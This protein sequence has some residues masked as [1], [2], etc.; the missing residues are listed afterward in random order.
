MKNISALILTCDKNSDI[1]QFV[2]KTVDLLSSS[3]IDTII[4][5]ESDAAPFGEH[6]IILRKNDFV[7]RMIQGIKSISDDYVLVLLD[8]YYVFDGELGKKVEYWKY[9]ISAFN[10]DVLCVSSDN[11]IYKKTKKMSGG[12][13]IFKSLRMYDID[14][15]PTIWKKSV[16]LDLLKSKGNGSPWELEP[17]F[18]IFIKSKKLIC[19]ISAQKIKYSELIIGGRF[20]RKPYF[21]YC[22]NIYIGN[23][24][25]RGGAEDFFFSFKRFLY[26]ITPRFVIDFFGRITKHR[27]YS[28]S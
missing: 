10:F 5:S 17:F 8:D 28:H 13:R 1:S 3:G 15:H 11:K 26:H 22:K 4:A 18:T 2:L 14:F 27:R 20:F 21:K 12:T 9:E 25:V 24:K 16:L 6:K 23:R 7:E 19:G